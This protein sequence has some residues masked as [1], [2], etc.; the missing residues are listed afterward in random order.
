[1]KMFALVATLFSLS[2]FAQVDTLIKQ[3]DG[4]V[5][6]CET[7]ADAF[8]H[9]FSSVYRPIELKQSE[10]QANIRIEF[11]KCVEN[12]DGYGFVRDNNIESRVLADEFIEERKLKIAK[13]NFSMIAVNG[14]GKLIDRASLKAND[15]GTFS[16]VLNTKADEYDLSPKGKKSLDVLVQSQFE[17]IDTNYNQVIDRG[18]E[19]L[20][21]YRLIIK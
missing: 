1:M 9:R 12:K 14:K 4:S 5:A 3:Y 20:G 17:I 18:I 10:N 21:S 19:S 2:S 7:K 6:R 13:K 16:A 15:D 8:Q 11:L